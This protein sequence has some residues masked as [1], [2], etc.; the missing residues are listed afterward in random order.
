[1]PVLV[2]AQ[3]K[4]FGEPG[5]H[6]GGFGCNAGFHL[7]LAPA[8]VM[9]MVVLRPNSRYLAI[10]NKTPKHATVIFPKQQHANLSRVMF[11]SADF[12]LL[13]KHRNLL[14]KWSPE[15]PQVVAL[16]DHPSNST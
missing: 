3:T 8:S 16:S 2:S 14:S 12:F 13:R 15:G 6:N 1:M 9:V 7:S 10:G 5:G 11:Q 4:D